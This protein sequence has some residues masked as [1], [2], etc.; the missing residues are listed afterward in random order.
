MDIDEILK[1][2]HYGEEREVNA[3][4]EEL[5]I[6]EILKELVGNDL[7]LEA[8]SSSYVTAVFHEWDLARFKFTKRAKWIA[9]PT[10]EVGYPKHYIESPEDVRNFPGLLQESLDII[11]KFI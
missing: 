11:Y 9:F 1:F 5:Q 3:K 10:A 2:S 6:F 8:K 4:D 7:E